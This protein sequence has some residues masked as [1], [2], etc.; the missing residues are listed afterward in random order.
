MNWKF[1]YYNSRV[2][3]EAL[4]LPADL[5]AEFKAMQ[6]LM[7]KKGPH[8]GMPFTR[9]MGDGLFEMRLRGKDTI[10]RI[11]YCTVIAGEIVVP[12]E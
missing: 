9:S 1:I 10:A 11:F 4:R 2:E 6:D 12:T 7:E 3:K 5:L 8:L